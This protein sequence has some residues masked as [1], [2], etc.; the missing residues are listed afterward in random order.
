MKSAI[1]KTPLKRLAGMQPAK[2]RTIR[3]AIARFAADPSARQ[4]NV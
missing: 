2:A 4:A 3:K 1:K